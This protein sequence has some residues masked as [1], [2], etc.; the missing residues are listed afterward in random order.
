MI[1]RMSLFL[2]MAMSIFGISNVSF[3]LMYAG[4]SGHG[5]YA[6]AAQSGGSEHAHEA[7]AK[8]AASKTVKVKAEEAGNAICPVSGEKI[9]E[10]LKATYEYEGKIYNFCCTSCIEE[11][12]KDPQKYIKKMEQQK[13]EQNKAG[14]E[15]EPSSEIHA[16]SQE[17]H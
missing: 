12:K 6:Q 11:F 16:H 8:T 1:K 14:N 10:K 15:K 7:D 13:E 4:D 5:D 17:Y 3:A 2:V 9:D